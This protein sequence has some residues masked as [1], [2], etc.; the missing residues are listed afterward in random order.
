MTDDTI[1]PWLQTMAWGRAGFWGASA[2]SQR[3]GI[4][5]QTREER[6]LQTRIGMPKKV[7]TPSLAYCPRG[8][9]NR[10]SRV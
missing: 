1:Y 5:A 9:Q 3:V 8:H 7:G 10:T 6:F 4:V 2:F